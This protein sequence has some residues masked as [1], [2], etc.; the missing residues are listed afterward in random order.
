MSDGTSPRRSF[1]LARV[2]AVVLVADLVLLLLLE[3]TSRLFAPA[4]DDSRLGELS[5]LSVALGLPALQKAVLFDRTLFWKLR[6]GLPPT[7]VEGRIGPSDPIRFRLSTTAEGFRAPDPGVSPVIVS[8]GDSCTFG[9]AVEDGE[10]FPAR[11]QAL[12]GLPVLNAGVPGY[13]SF[14]GRRLLEER[15]RVWRPKAVV[16]QFGWNDAAVWDGR[17]DAEH[18]GLLARGPGLLARSRLIQLLLPLLPGRESRVGDANGAA[19]RPR[20]SPAEFGE[21]IRAMVRLSRAEGAEPLLVLWPARHHL[22]GVRIPPHLG[23]L[24]QVAA[25]D[26]VLLVDLLEVF[27]REGGTSLYADAVHANASGHRVV[28]EA[29][30]GAFRTLNSPITGSTPGSPSAGASDRPASPPP[31]GTRSPPSSSSSGR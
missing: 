19:A 2:A 28:A 7:L 14:Q 24:R 1:S 31:P 4:A 29:I 17:S 6:P 5:R 21:E 3:G 26:G 15:I 8:L 10:T 11:L 23:V 30:A 18:A 16:L 27:S 12:T 9:L 20:L 13:S 25:S 22:G